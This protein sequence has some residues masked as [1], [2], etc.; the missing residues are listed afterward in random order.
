MLLLL[1][2]V[3]WV[4]GCSGLEVL[5]SAPAV[6]CWCLLLLG[7]GLCVSAGAVGT[8]CNNRGKLLL[9]PCLAGCCVAE[10]CSGSDS[11]GVCKG[12]PCPAS[13][14]TLVHKVAH[15]KPTLLDCG[16]SVCV[17]NQSKPSSVVWASVC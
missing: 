17:C 5:A 1:P 16:V 9:L 13:I 3:L 15:S 6:G 8:S 7:H 10:L 14:T 12:V 11:C 2:V 4:L